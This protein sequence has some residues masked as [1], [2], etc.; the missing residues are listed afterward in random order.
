MLVYWKGINIYRDYHMTF[1]CQIRTL[2]LYVATFEQHLNMEYIYFSWYDIPDWPL[3]N[4]CVTNDHGYLPLVVETSPSFPLS[5][6]ING[7]TDAGTAYPSAFRSTWIHPLF[8]WG[9][10]HSI[11]S[12]LCMFCRS[13]FVLLSFFFWPLCCLSFFDLWILITPLVSCSSSYQP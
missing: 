11:F 1:L 2:H 12:F 9:W 3:W 6:L 8:Y 4:I 5:W 13:L 10:S 7:L